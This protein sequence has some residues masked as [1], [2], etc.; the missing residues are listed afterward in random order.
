[1]KPERLRQ[2]PDLERRDLLKGLGLGAAGAAATLMPGDAARAAES[3]R[4]Q[5]KARYRETD[6][7]KRFYALNR[8]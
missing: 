6:H 2:G 4:E 1:M 7:V 5:V 8:L 3:P